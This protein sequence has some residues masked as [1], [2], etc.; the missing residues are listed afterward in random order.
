MKTEALRE[1]RIDRVAVA[2]VTCAVM[3]TEIERKF[4]VSGDDWRHGARCRRIR[5]GYLSDA[6]ERSVRVRIVGNEAWLTI[7]GQTTGYSRVEFEYPLPATDAL[8]LLETL[9]LQPII[10]KT[11]H[12]L[13]HGAH[14]WEVDEFHGAN[15]GLVIAEIELSAEDEHFDRPPWLGAEVSDDPRYFNASLARRPFKDW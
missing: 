14:L 11:R 15:A 6:P 13:R 7:K 8:R 1:S 4:L 5:Q 9:C 2:G 10:D 12:E 3:A